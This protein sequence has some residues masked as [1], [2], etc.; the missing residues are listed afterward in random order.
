VTANGDVYRHHLPSYPQ[1]QLVSNVFSGPTPATQ[2]TWG[3]E[4]PLS[5]RA[6]RSRINSFATRQGRRRKAWAQ[7]RRQS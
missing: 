2:E 7:P 1:W 4:G 3:G 6:R 5:L